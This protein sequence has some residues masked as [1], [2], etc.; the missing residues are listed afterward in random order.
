M[1]YHSGICTLRFENSSVFS[2]AIASD[3]VLISPANSE[4]GMS[5]LMN[6]ATPFS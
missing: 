3:V 1:S 4:S 5:L 6:V 2:F